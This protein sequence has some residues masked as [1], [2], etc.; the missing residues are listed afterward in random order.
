MKGRGSRC[1]VLKCFGF[2]ALATSKVIFEVTVQVKHLSF[3]KFEQYPIAIDFANAD[4]RKNLQANVVSSMVKSRPRD[5]H[6]PLG[7]KSRLCR[8]CL[9][10]DCVAAQMQRN[11][12]RQRMQGQS[13]QETS[14]HGSHLG[15]WQ[16]SG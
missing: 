13:A 9:G 12:A 6:R 4:W 14:R 1:K 11:D 15:Y 16:Y 3:G 8:G 5:R 2:D 10:I 7:W